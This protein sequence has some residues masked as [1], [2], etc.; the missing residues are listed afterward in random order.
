M[1]RWLMLIRI[2]VRGEKERKKNEKMEKNV[3]RGRGN[4]RV[5]EDSCKKK[6]GESVGRVWASQL[7]TA[8]R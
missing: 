3:G 5:Q 6:K 4:K 7:M 8:S 2:W 1:K